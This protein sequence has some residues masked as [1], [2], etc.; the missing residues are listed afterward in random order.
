MHS[1]KVKEASDK[2]RIKRRGKDSFE[3]RKTYVKGE[4]Y[5]QVNLPIEYK[6]VNGQ[7]VRIQKRRTLRDREEA[8]TIAEQ[9]RVQAK[10]DGRKS[11]AIPDSVRRDALAAVK[12]L[13]PFGATILEAA[14][15]YAAHLRRQTTSQKVSIAVREFLAAR[16][17][18]ELRPRYLKDLRVRLNKF[19]Q[20]FGD[21]TIASI[22]A[23]EIGAWLRAFKPFNRN[24]FRLRLS[25]LFGYA[26]EQ[27]WCQINPV[28]EVKKV[29]ASS[30]IGI[31]TPEQFAKLLETAKDETLPYWLIGG[32]GGLRRS[33]IE[34]LEWKDV[35]F[36]SGLIEV[37]ALKSKT[38]SRR[39]V[40]IETALASWLAPYKGRTGLV[41]P[42]DLRYQLELDR[43]TTGLWK[44]TA[45]GIKQLKLKGIEINPEN[46][47]HLKA[48]PTNALRHSFASHHLAHFK[49]AARLA[50]E[51]G[52]TNQE[53]LFRH[54]RELVT[55]EQAQKWWNIQPAADSA[56]VAISA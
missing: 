50:L 34:R 30:Q 32:F 40:K 18:D 2:K 19:S 7:R 45:N 20:S 35:R 55:P 27:K 38:A 46:F 49:D 42:P 1:R 29:K 21:R 25:A 26:V 8:E 41:C 9:A 10:N 53:L 13:E 15:F 17:K 24:T 12:E 56:L 5:W 22:S 11:F 6:V 39:F 43:L 52:H 14:K 51:L 33:E 37:P 3:P 28:G 31:I 44:P 4:V 23:G 48:W 54:Y 36:D 16:G 47:K